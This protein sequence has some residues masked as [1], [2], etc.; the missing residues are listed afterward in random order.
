MAQAAPHVHMHRCPSIATSGSYGSSA[1]HSLPDS[2]ENLLC[3][4]R[5]C[6]RVMLR[7]SLDSASPY[8]V[9]SHCA[10]AAASCRGNQF[11]TVQRR[12]ANRC[13]GNARHRSVR[14]EGIPDREPY[15]SLATN[16]GPQAESVVDGHAASSTACASQAPLSSRRQRRACRSHP[17]PTGRP[18]GAWCER[19]CYLVTHTRGTCS[20][21][22]RTH[23]H[24]CAVPR[25]AH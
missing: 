4:R 21:S 8:D 3:S 18:I 22:T 7:V 6:A 15:N 10:Y 23:A 24:I 17:S 11:V 13:L 20:W 2:S 1:L 9:R 16:T 12:H 19:R 5:L 14:D 25:G